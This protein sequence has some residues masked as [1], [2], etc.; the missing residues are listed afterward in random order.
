MLFW[1]LSKVRYNLILSIRAWLLTANRVC[2]GRAPKYGNIS[3]NSTITLPIRSF[4][5]RMAVRLSTP[6]CN[7]QSLAN[8]CLHS[9][10]SRTIRNRTSARVSVPSLIYH[11]DTPTDPAKPWVWRTNLAETKPFWEDWFVGLS[12]KFLEARGGKLL[13]LAGT[14]RLDKELMIGQMQGLFLIS[15]F[16]QVTS[17]AC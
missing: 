9:T 14:D 3:L 16:T 10:R 12:R 7:P 11:E 17:C 6:T 5:D 15:F 1:M 2:N 13:L 4:R 8:D